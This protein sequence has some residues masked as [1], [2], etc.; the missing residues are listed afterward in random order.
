MGVLDAP[1]FEVELEGGRA[2][3]G[4]FQLTREGTWRFLLREGEGE[5]PSLDFPIEIEPDNPPTVDLE[6]SLDRV[7]VAWDQRIPVQWSARDD[8]G[9]ERVG[10]TV[11]D[12]E[13]ELRA[14]LDVVRNLQGDLNRTPE[15]LGL[16]PGDEAELTIQAWDN[17]EVGG[18]KPG[19]SRT[20]KVV[21]LGPKASKRRT[22]RLW[23]E[24]RD[25]LVDLL[26]GYA[27]E[28]VPPARTQRALV[29]W[30]GEAAVRFEPMDSL[31]DKYWDAFD[32]GT[33][34]GVIVEEL[35]RLGG[36]MLRFVS[37]VADPRSREKVRAEDLDTVV[38]LRDELV[39]RGEEGVHVLDAMLRMQALA[40]VNELTGLLASAA[41]S[42]EARTTSELIPQAAVRSWL[43]TISRHSEQL[44]AAAKEFDA[45]GLTDLVVRSLEEAGRIR[46]RMVESMAD[47]NDA[48]T[49]LLAGYLEDVLGQLL[50]GVEHMRREAEEEG[51]EMEDMLKKFREK[52]MELEAGERDLLSE[53]RQARED[54]GGGQDGL[55][56][57]W[58]AAEELAGEALKHAEWASRG[59]VEEEGFSAM[60][61]ALA[62]QAAIQSARLLKV[63][64]ARDLV[65]SRDQVGRTLLRLGSTRRTVIQHEG[66]REA[67]GA[68]PPTIRQ[69][70]GHLE[71]GVRQTRELDQLL[72]RLDGY[73]NDAPPGLMARALELDRVQQ[74]LE[75]ETVGAEPTAQ[76]VAQE[77]PMGAPGLEEG[78][79]G[80][81][82]EIGRSRAALQ[83]GR[84]VEAEGAEGAA[85][86]RLLQAREALE[87]AA[88]AMQQM[89]DAMEQAGQHGGQEQQGGGRG[90]ELAR[91]NQVEIPPPEEFETPEAY[92]RALL[93]GM[94]GE[95]PPEYE[96]LKRRYYEELVR[97]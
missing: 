75:T 95:V 5:I 35:Q 69:Q 80:A 91:H 3:S 20:I 67:V 42:L 58:E 61:E 63:V 34:E 21:V 68:S 37:A 14:P 7:E 50:A 38:Q 65:G 92:R 76:Q 56:E 49:R 89:R 84:T 27:T 83:G 45:H 31:V 33:V 85:A 44:Q 70:L 86:E 41:A 28:R 93:E 11:Q 66:V 16:A 8:F 81:V 48:R 25:A 12:R 2:L 46:E 82:R 26:A 97:Q 51:E 36:S 4:G 39:E 22:V 72:E 59:V 23:R 96:A 1:P 10:V 9:I 94:K 78:V 74:A 29:V 79:A 90:D 73:A 55:V 62:A 53:T 64:G 24:L 30:G 60:E 19:A 54:L 17:D 47:G 71:G 6:S 52:L 18:S 87:Q 77:L 57:L 43:D 15:E 32:V 40:R 13:V 88:A